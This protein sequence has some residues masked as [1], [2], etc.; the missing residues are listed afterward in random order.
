MIN[1]LHS[2]EYF[3]EGTEAQYKNY[4]NFTNLKQYMLGFNLRAEWH[5][6]ATSHGKNR[7]DGI[8]GTLNI[9]MWLARKASLQRPVYGE[10]L[11]CEAL[12][13]WCKFKENIKNIKT[14]YVKQEE[15]ESFLSFNSLL[16]S[17]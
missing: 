5:F 15:I 2:I 7:C 3:R 13:D 16:N 4:K 17:D 14:F 9:L 6:F 8:D 12:F 1:G 11:T 10:I